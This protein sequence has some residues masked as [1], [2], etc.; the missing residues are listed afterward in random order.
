MVMSS[1]SILKTD[2]LL[3]ELPKINIVSAKR[4]CYKPSNE[5]H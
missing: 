5:D 4:L 1:A 2:R 3:R